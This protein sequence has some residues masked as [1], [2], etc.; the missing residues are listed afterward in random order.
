[1][2]MTLTN[3]FWT[4]V[5]TYLFGNGSTTIGTV[6]SS[7]SG[8]LARSMDTLGSFKDT[9]GTTRTKVSGSYNSSSADYSGFAGSLFYFASQWGIS[10]AVG[11]G[12]T[13]ATVDDYNVETAIAN[14]SVSFT[15]QN[16]ANGSATFHVV[17]TATA[18]ISV[19]E[20]CMF[21]RLSTDCISG[22]AYSVLI[23]RAVLD[24]PVALANGE[25]KT[26]DVTISL[27]M[28]A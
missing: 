27:P 19:S 11:S 3:N 24:T 13:A 23:G 9:S 26:F 22:T 16:S 17:V 25:S 28:P 14:A 1:M 15:G 4:S 20:I 21:K 8:I 6:V 2:E 12:T 5:R 7:G 10:F 18:D